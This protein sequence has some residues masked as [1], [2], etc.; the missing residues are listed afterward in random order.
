VTALAGAPVGVLALQGGYEAHEKAVQ[1]LGWSTRR[2]KTP[3]DL[4]GL[5]GLVFPG[6]ESST[7]LKLIDWNGLWGPLD[8]FV[9]SG[10]PV[11]ATC[12]GLILAARGVANPTQQSF[13]WLDVDV[14]RNAWGRQNESFEAVDD[15]GVLRMVFIRAPRITRVG[16]GVEVVATYSG[17]A[18]AVRS[19]GSGVNVTAA[20]FHP[21]L[22]GEVGLHRA[23][24]GEPG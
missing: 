10:R 20:T 6:G 4:E 22:A 3:V 18:V 11:L 12:A 23:A 17:E 8:G 9:R 19:G 16:E 13:G 5:A 24:F 1:S 14:S 15:A 7:M 2:V 21:E